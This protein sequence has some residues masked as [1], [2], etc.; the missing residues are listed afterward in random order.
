MVYLS[1][2]DSLNSGLAH[3]DPI[4]GAVLTVGGGKMQQVRSI[5]CQQRVA[6]EVGAKTTC[7]KGTKQNEDA[8]DMRKIIER[9]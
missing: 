1:L 5:L 7:K 2:L 9:S 3:L 6:G 4:A 8:V